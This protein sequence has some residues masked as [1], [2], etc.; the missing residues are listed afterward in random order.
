MPPIA[1]KPKWVKNVCKD[2]IDF[3]D[4][5]YVPTLIEVSPYKSLEEYMKKKIPVLNQ[6]DTN[7]CTG[8]SLTTAAHYLFKTRKINPL[9]D[10]LSPFMIYGLARRYD[11]FNTI[12]DSGSSIRAGMK[13]WHKHGLSLINKWNKNYNGNYTIEIA[14]DAATRPLGAYYRVNHKDIVAMH[15]ALTEVGILYVSAGIGSGWDEVGKD[16]II[17]ENG[18]DPAGHAFVIVGYDDKG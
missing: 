4:K 5:I 11:E 2:I 7:A 1:A 8:F 18:K 16:G 15:C 14:Q 3:R 10:A 6:G 13:A 9:S 12:D 17:K